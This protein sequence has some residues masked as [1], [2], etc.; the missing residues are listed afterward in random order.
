MPTQQVQVIISAIDKTG[1]TIKDVQRRM[2]TLGKGFGDLGKRMTDLGK[3]MSVGITVPLAGMA[4]GVKKFTEEAS[5]FKMVKESFETMTRGMVSD[6]DDFLRAMK[7]ATAGTLSNY[8]IL[9]SAN[10]ALSLI[11]KEAFGDFQKDFANMADYVRKAARATGFSMDYLWDS[12]VLGV[13]RGSK[14]ILDNLGITVDL[15]RAEEEWAKQLGKT[16]EEL[17][18]SERKTADLRHVL[19]LLEDNY[20]NIKIEGASVA[21]K[22]QAMKARMKDLRD[23]IGTQLIPVVNTLI[24]AFAEIWEEVGPMI[25]DTIK[26]IVEAFTGLDKKW[27]LTI[28]GIIGAIGALGPVLIVFG[29]LIATIKNLSEALL[30]LKAILLPYGLLFLPLIPII[31]EFIENWDFW[32][33]I[34]TERTRQVGKSFDTVI[35]SISN[36]LTEFMRK[37]DEWIS[38]LIDSFNVLINWGG[39]LKRDWIDPLIDAV[40]EVEFQF[41]VAFNS[42]KNIV[43]SVFEWITDKIDWFLGKWD[44]LKGKISDI[45]RFLLPSGIWTKQVPFAG[46][47]LQEGGI[48]PGPIGAPVPAIVHGGELVVPPDKRVGNTFNFDFRG[49]FI[50]DVDSFKRQIIEALN[51]ESELRAIGGQ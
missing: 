1:K 23:E 50:G 6:T 38:Y 47:R 15:T 45:K 3:K 31:K 12:I 24:D 21:E 20:G 35:K 51:R 18:E 27:Q 8:D 36:W 39:K 37:C 9:T 32:G 17:T 2:D 30:F 44:I 42:I 46:I 19:S 28:I 22:M 4:L 33:D 43:G 25:V 26:R 48:V 5:K 10:R 29:Q 16:R 13:G 40:S 34:V 14:M 49:A 7:V 41:I 11:G